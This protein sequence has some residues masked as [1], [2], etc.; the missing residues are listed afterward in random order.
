MELFN[1][2]LKYDPNKEQLKIFFEEHNLNN[3]LVNICH[4]NTDVEII[5]LV[6]KKYKIDPTQK[7]KMQRDLPEWINKRHQATDK[8]ES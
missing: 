2:I 7:C 5:K 4:I 6:I 1:F 3:H 8:R